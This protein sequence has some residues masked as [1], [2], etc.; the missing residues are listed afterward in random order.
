MVPV[1]RVLVILLAFIVASMV[2]ALVITLAILFEW[3]QI[4][5]TTDTSAGWLAVG[6]FSLILSIKCLLPAALVIAL[7]EALALRS[8]LFYAGVGG[9]G[10]VALYYALG[11][12]DSGPGG[13][14]LARRDLE[15]MAGAG[16]AGGFV[17]WAIAGRSAGAWRPQ[18]P[19]P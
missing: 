2:A 10:L 13:S 19:S 4:L 6:F 15:I 3:E 17:Y 7:A 18:P 5:A 16:I 12:A 9:I 11:L 8:P 1:R 14:V